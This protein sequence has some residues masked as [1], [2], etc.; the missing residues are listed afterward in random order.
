MEVDKRRWFSATVRLISVVAGVG[1]VDYMDCVHLFRA[2]D[3]E[4]AFARALMLGRTHETE[5]INMNGNALR[6]RL[7][8]VLTLDLILTDNLDGAEVRSSMMDVPPAEQASFDT[9]FHPEESKPT[10]TM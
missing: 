2:T 7:K 10:Q 1:A 8:E 4:D 9:E 3:W 6:Q 5:Y